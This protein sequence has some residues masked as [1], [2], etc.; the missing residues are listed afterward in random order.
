M[1]RQ[2]SERP[3]AGCTGPRGPWGTLDLILSAVRSHWGVLCGK[4]HGL[5]V[6]WRA[7]LGERREKTEFFG[8]LSVGGEEMTNL[9][10]S[11]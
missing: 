9:R 5:A 2:L 10:L 6:V 3:G 4:W 7:V 8:G 1:G 11:V